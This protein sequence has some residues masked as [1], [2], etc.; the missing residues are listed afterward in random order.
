MDAIDRREDTFYVV[1]FRRDHLLLPAISHNKTSRPK[2]SLVMPAMA[3]NE[4]L[5]NSSL[6]YEVMMQID[7]EVMDT[8]VIHIKS[9]TVPP[10]LKRQE[11]TPDNRT[12]PSP[13]AFSGRTTRAALRP[14]RPTLSSARRQ[15]H[16]TLYL[17]E[18]AGE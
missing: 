7:C 4:S 10:F 6:G 2:M 5:Y 11:A 1:S 17:G 12:Q 13:Q 15:P 18:N 3:L 14:Q 8:R 9:S 16:R